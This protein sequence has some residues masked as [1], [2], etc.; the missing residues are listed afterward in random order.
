MKVKDGPFLNPDFAGEVEMLFHG[1]PADFQAQP[2][3][4]RPIQPLPGLDFRALNARTADPNQA[5]EDTWDLQRPGLT[6]EIR[7][8]LAA[9]KRELAIEAFR[10]GGSPT[11]FLPISWARWKE[12]LAVNSKNA[13]KTRLARLEKLGLVEILASERGSWGSSL[14]GYR[15]GTGDGT[16]A[17]QAVMEA[18][19]RSIKRLKSSREAQ[20]EA[21][22]TSL[23]PGHAYPG[24]APD[25]GTRLSEEMAKQGHPAL[26]TPPWP[27]A[28][29]PR[30]VPGSRTVQN[31]HDSLA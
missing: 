28:W 31:G 3:S 26:Q 20:V 25:N 13:A 9:L 17:F 5:V 14:N 15:L 24:A 21:A 7:W 12:L 16:K 4:H 23:N 19:E 11:A 29:R 18:R 30:V 2:L 8:T 27:F 1:S 6:D 22:D 10:W